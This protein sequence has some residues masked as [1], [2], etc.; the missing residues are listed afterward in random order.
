MKKSKPKRDSK[1][2]ARVTRLSPEK[3]A[4]RDEGPRLIPLGPK[5]EQTPFQHYLGAGGRSA[6]SQKRAADRFGQA[7]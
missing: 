2:S 3:A 7:D 5:K 6:H 1:K 4:A